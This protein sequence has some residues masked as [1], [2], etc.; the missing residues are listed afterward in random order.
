[1]W[2]ILEQKCV[3]DDVQVKQNVDQVMLMM[4][5]KMTIHVTEKEEDVLEVGGAEEW[6]SQGGK[7]REG[8]DR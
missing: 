7:R 2:G 4:M 3:K 5:K 1:M 6:R 8:G